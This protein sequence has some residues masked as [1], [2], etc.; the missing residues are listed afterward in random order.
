MKIHRLHFNSSIPGKP[1]ITGS[2]PWI[3]SSYCSRKE[4]FQIIDTEPDALPVIQPT[5]L[6]KENQSSDPIKE[7]HPLA[8]SFFHPSLDFRGSRHCSPYAGLWLSAK[9][10]VQISPMSRSVKVIHSRT[11]LKF[12]KF[13]RDARG[14]GWCCFI[15]RLHGGRIRAVVGEVEWSRGNKRRIQLDLRNLRFWRFV[16]VRHTEAANIPVTGSHLCH[17]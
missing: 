9:V 1:G 7:S 17:T 10:F 2:P 8:S 3:S 14:V 16:L 5:V 15:C 12:R 4:P 13:H 11:H 6:K